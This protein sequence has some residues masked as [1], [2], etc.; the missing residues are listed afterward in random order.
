MLKLIGYDSNLLVPCFSQRGR[1]G[2]TAPKP[3]VLIPPR[4]GQ[5][6]HATY[7]SVLSRSLE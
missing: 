1:L 5:A 4:A 7:A 6:S 3:P 2:V